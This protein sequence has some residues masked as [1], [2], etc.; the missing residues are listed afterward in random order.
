M[1]H[2]P[3]QLTKEGEILIKDFLKMSCDFKDG[4]YICSKERVEYFRKAKTIK[5]NIKK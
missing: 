2:E 3:T 5:N 1:D 4:V